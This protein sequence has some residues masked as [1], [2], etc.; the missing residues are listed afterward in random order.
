MGVRGIMDQA[1]KRLVLFDIDGTLV[2]GNGLG[3]QCFITSLREFFDHDGEMP[4]LQFA[5]GTDFA[6]FDQVAQAF[7][8]EV[9]DQDRKLFFKLM[10]AELE[11]ALLEK[12]G[13]FEPIPGVRECLERLQGSGLYSLG[14][15]TGNIE[16]T[17]WL[18]LRSAGLHE[19]FDFGGGF[20]DTTAMRARIVEMA[21]RSFQDRG[22]KPAGKVVMVGD[23]P[24][25]VQAAKAV[26]IVPVAVLTGVHGEEAFLESQ[27]VKLIRSLTELSEILEK[28]HP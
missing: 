15:V 14:I 2:R 23:T 6:L 17:A 11:D 12:R 28:E 9:E 10:A 21:M 25:D 18:K 8:F 1:T 7:G 16:A 5:G 26:G 24:Q 13:K 4:K 19:F 22:F 3:S 20:G 27:P